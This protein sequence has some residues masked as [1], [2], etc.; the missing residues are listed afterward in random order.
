MSIL[1]I[2]T[3]FGIRAVSS[4]LSVKMAVG[5]RGRDRAILRVADEGLREEIRTL[6]A[7]LEAVEVGR[8]RDPKGGDDSEEENTA[9]TDASNEEGLEIKLL[10]SVLL[11]SSKP[12]PKLSNYDGILSTKALLNWISELD[13]YF[14]YE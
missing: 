11:A 6:I 4:F 3:N 2:A 12:R 14:E 13:K 7:R 8:R 5:R 1:G 9:T 10:R